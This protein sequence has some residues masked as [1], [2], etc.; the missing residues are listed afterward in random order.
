MVGSDEM[1]RCSRIAIGGSPFSW[2]LATAAKEHSRRQRNGDF[3][4]SRSKCRRIRQMNRWTMNRRGRRRRWWCG[5]KWA[6][7]VIG[8]KTRASSARP[9]R[10]NDLDCGCIITYHPTVQVQRIL[11][12]ISKWDNR[13]RSHQ[14]SASHIL[15]SFSLTFT[16]SRRSLT[17]IDIDIIEN[18]QS[19]L[20]LRPKWDHDVFF[21]WIMM[22]RDMLVRECNAMIVSHFQVQGVPLAG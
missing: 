8:A 20:L 16:L 15:L 9:T 4:A 6:K 3:I 7:Q 18:Y 17:P 10:L 12:R 1:V 13:K 11:L 14:R 5:W 2:L 22:R 19:S 21:R